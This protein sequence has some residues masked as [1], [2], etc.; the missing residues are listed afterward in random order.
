MN[1]KIVF[2]IETQKS[3][4]EVGGR[5]K[6]HLL[7][8]SV[9]AA[10][11]YNYKKCFV[12]DEGNIYDFQK[13][14]DTADTLIGFNS[15][16]FDVPILRSY[17]FKLDKIHSLDLMEDVKNGVGF[18]VALDNIANATLG[19]NKTADGLQALKWYK[20]GNIAAIK[21]YCVSD[22]QI[23]RDVYEYGKNNNHVFFV[24]REK[25]KVAVPVFWGAEK[26][27]NIKEILNDAFSNRRS[28]EIEYL[29]HFPAK[30]DEPKNIRIIDIYEISGGLVHGFCHLRNEKRVFKE[31]RILNA[32]ITDKTYKTEHD[33]QGRLL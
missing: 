31:D 9:L 13:M 20:E 33:I 28:V 16:G 12:F 25:G 11:S 4:E 23:T 22:V 3:F 1:D 21:K 24:N 17:N 18:R 10:Y 15:N 14:I 30:K 7:G 27:R 29:A 6:L 2:D 32:K 19:L 5:D 26:Q 8:I